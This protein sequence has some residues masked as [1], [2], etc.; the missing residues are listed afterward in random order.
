MPALVHHTE[1]NTSTEPARANYIE[2]RMQC[3]THAVHRSVSKQRTLMKIKHLV[4]TI[5]LALLAAASPA[6]AAY[7]PAPAD[8]VRAAHRTHAPPVS[9]PLKR[10]GWIICQVFTGRLCT[11]ALNVAWC[12][13]T[14]RTTA[15]NG[16]YRGMFQMGSSER[17]RFGHGRTAMKQA[18]AAKRYHNLSGWRPWACSP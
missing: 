5:L 11:P 17:A 7:R 12:E 16:Q 15:R 1:E 18:R 8:I 14:L 9:Q 6:Q 10:R 3:N 2:R 4:T 13:S